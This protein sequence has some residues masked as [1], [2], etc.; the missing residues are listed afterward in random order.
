M[1]LPFFSDSSDKK[2]PPTGALEDFVNTSPKSVYRFSAPRDTPPSKICRDG[3]DGEDCKTIELTGK[4]MFTTMQSMGFF[5]ALP[6]DPSK[7]YMECKPSAIPR[8]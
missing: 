6:L 2:Q 1:S 7:T 8:S 5:C 4:E 3:K